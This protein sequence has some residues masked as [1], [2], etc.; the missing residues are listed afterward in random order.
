MHNL[1]S[2]KGYLGR[3]A[4]WKIYGCLIVSL[5]II[6]GLLTQDSPVALVLGLAILA[7]HLWVA[8]ATI[9]KRLRDAGYPVW[10]A[11]IIYIPLLNIA[12]LIICFFF[13]T[14]PKVNEVLG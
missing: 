4:F 11:P 9:V 3:K 13:K 7:V 10:I 8:L 14:D 6:R 12:I 1:F 5:L 2:F